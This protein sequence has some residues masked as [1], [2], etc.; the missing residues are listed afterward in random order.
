MGMLINMAA[1]KPGMTVILHICSRL[2]GSGRR[3]RLQER[4][5]GAA[6]IAVRVKEFSKPA[7]FTMYVFSNFRK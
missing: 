5:D 3:Q 6:I 1:T 7:H 2:M 4:F